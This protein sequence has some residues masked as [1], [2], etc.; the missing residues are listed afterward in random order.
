MR[1]LE[2]RKKEIVAGLIGN[3]LSIVVG[4]RRDSR[5]RGLE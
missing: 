5:W 1:G 3:K 2:R 4:M